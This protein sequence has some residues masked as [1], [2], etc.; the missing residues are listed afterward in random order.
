MSEHQQLWNAVESVGVEIRV[1]ENKDCNPKLNNGRRFF[2]WYHGPAR[3]LVICQ[4]VALRNNTF[5]QGQG[6]WS[7]E[8][9]DTLRHEAHHMVQDCRDNELNQELDAVY[10]K[11]VVLALEVLG[12]V[13]AQSIV[14]SYSDISEH[15]QVMELEAFAVA[16]INDPLDQVADIKNY[17]F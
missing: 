16:E 17:C 10:T 5:G 7:E 15:R 8:D 9:L 3:S 13:R 2:G 11:P 4:E 12:K 14:E 1:N 6:K